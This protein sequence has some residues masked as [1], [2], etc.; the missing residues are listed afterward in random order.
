MTEEDRHQEE[1]E[2]QRDE[3]R[4]HDDRFDNEVAAAIENGEQCHS[5]DAVVKVVVTELGKPDSELRRAI[6]GAVNTEI[7]DKKSELH[8]LCN[9]VFGLK[10][11]GMPS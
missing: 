10:N 2:A 1:L 8:F 11:G 9:G 4:Y 5:W 3:Q 6:L 7:V